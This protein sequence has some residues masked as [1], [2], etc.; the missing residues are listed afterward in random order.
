M[1]EDGELLARISDTTDFFQSAL[2][3]DTLPD[4]NLAKD[5]GKFLVR[6]LPDDIMGHA[7]LVRAYRHLGNLELARYELNQCREHLKTRQLQK[8]EGDDFLPLLAVEEHFLS[9]EVT[10]GEPD[11]G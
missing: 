7:F 3:R 4:W 10:S 6:I 8:W 2:Y 9:G 11:K 5:F 1:S